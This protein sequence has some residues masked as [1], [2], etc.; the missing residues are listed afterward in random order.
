[1]ATRPNKRQREAQLEFDALSIEGGL[2]APEWLAHAAQAKAPLQ[3]DAD[4]RI[5]KGLN[6]RDEIG[7]YW[8]IAQAQWGEFAKGRAAGAEPRMLSERFVHKLLQR[9]FGFESLDVALP[10][11]V[12]DRQYPIGFSALHGRVPVVIAPAPATDVARGLEVQLTAFGESGRKRS[13]FG[14][15]QEYLNAADGALWGI[16]CDGLTLRILR[17]N[18]SLTRPAWIEADLQRIFVEERFADFAALWLLAHETRFGQPDQ[19]VA[20]CALEQWRE[21][22]RQEGTRAREQLRRGV[23]EALRALG[24][25]FLAHP[26]NT[27]LRAALHDGS[28]SKDQ[29]FQ[30][31]L[32][33][34]YRLIFLLTIEERGLLHPTDTPE[35]TRKLYEGGYSL[36]RLRD[37]AV[38]RSAHD[39]FADLWQSL[40]IV[41]RGLVGGEPQLGLPALAGLFSAEQC[42]HLDAASLEN[43]ALLLAMFRLS[44]LRE[45]AGLARVN[46]RDMGPEELG[47]VYES[48]L[49]L[50]PQIGNG[51]RSFGFATGDEQKG[52]ARKTTGS[53]YT[54][55]SLVQVLL[56]SALEPVIEQTIAANPGRA[57][58][59]LLEL[60]VVDPACGSG[61]FL[62]G[63]AWRLAGHVA[64]LQTDGTPSTVEY[65]RALRQVVSRCIYGVDL[66]PMAVELCRVGLWMLAIEPGLP[67]NFLKAHVRHGN[68]LLGAAPEMMV[69]GVPDDA[70]E[71]AE[72]D[73]RKVASALKKRNKQSASGQVSLETLWAVPA[74][75]ES[76]SVIKAFAELEAA[77]DEDPEA[78][79]Q[80]EAK[81]RAI[82]ESVAHKHQTFVADTWCAAFVWPKR[83]GD[84]E[85]AAPTN[86][87]W[88]QLRDG[89]GTVPKETARVVQACFD[90]YRFFH[91]YLAFPQVFGRGG[92][93]VVLGNPP[94]VA[95]AD[96]GAKAMG[97]YFGPAAKSAD[98]LA[99][100]FLLLGHRICSSRG[101]VGLVVPKSISYSN[102]W[103]SLR[104]E[105]APSI[106]VAVDVGKAWDT[107]LLE[108]LII[109][110]GKF[111][112]G[113]GD[114]ARVV[115]GVLDAKD[116][117][118]LR[119]RPLLLM[120]RLGIIPTGASEIDLACLERV[121]Q[122]SQRWLSDLCSTQRGAPLQRLV[123]ED[124]Q[125]LP[126]FAG[127][128]IGV[129]HMKAPTRFID[130][131]ALLGAG[132]RPLAEPRAAF[133][134]II[135]HVTKPASHI[136][137]IGTVLTS[138]CATLD[139][140]N[141]LASDS[142]SPWAVVAYLSSNF[143]NWY[144]YVCVFNRAIR[145]MHFDG[146]VLRKLPVPDALEASQLDRVG[147]DLSNDP[148][149]PRY[150]HEL[151]EIVYDSV[152]F[153]PAQRVHIESQHQ[154]RWAEGR[155]D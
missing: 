97:S 139:T 92:F 8:R 61:H 58:E 129:F 69:N 32:R 131:A 72:G 21:A 93:D 30:Q 41:F 35:P 140:V 75:D 119:S 28:L 101:R 91:W 104:S 132:Y 152:G 56:D 108:Q 14:L 155:G 54:P 120:Q 7:R 98:N 1:M 150:W 73:D 148:K 44:W 66:N 46:W 122:S 118:A 18:A 126:V 70:W 26:D 64:R 53:Y 138:E 111:Q 11:T 83:A 19:P 80:K 55:D 15:A 4:Y 36:R 117:L 87:L 74:L 6:L 38:R 154:P 42:A 62:L 43:R 107:V 127:R 52:N 141:L 137:L 89:V 76:A 95:A 39:R 23:E 109:V 153:T 82:L 33:L 151:N 100:D 84:Q 143:A 57:V 130:R 45:K 124:P 116:G 49:E 121:G 25:G 85:Q 115:L 67:L 128:D 112:H 113:G 94:Y 34:V 3:S 96:A 60:T 110:L 59:A 16:A 31:L 48:L 50:V 99:A 144:V 37:R 10:V 27:A 40:R 88:R 81:F 51:G 9:C 22:G 77:G 106:R 136:K 146:F 47:S 29:Y 78:L 86:D 5:E 63:A 90:K 142:L 134:N 123:S 135:A 102:A 65:Q 133:Q 2:L 105:L 114:A 145:T 103:E 71:P 147:R 13:A 149:E 79:A 125:G 68:A 12:G 17:D 24:Q 20:D